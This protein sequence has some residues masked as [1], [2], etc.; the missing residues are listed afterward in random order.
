MVAAQA[1][2]SLLIVCCLPPFARTSGAA[3]FGVQALVLTNSEGAISTPS[4]K[5]WKC[6]DAPKSVSSGQP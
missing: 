6:W 5:L 1:Y 3:Y 4:W 2:M